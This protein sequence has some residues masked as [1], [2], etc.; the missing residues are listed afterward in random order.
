MDKYAIIVDTKSFKKYMRKIDKESV[1]SIGSKEYV[2]Y[3]SAKNI[4]SIS[5]TLHEENE[6]LKN[7]KEVF[8]IDLIASQGD[9]TLKW[10]L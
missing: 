7:F 2:V 4:K 6:I 5:D 1:K 3:R 10:E 9:D 8:V